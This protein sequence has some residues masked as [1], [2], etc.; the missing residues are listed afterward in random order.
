MAVS[1]NDCSEAEDEK[2][3]HQG[4]HGSSA[5]ADEHFELKKP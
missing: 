2:L 4:T 5:P 1:E 3:M